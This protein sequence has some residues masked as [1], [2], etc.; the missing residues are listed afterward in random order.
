[1]N[2]I[3]SEK[4]ADTGKVFIYGERLNLS[5]MKN[6]YDNVA[7]CPQHNPLWEELTLFEHLELYATIKGISKSKVRD[8]CKEYVVAFSF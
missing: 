2:I 7:F 3:T 8:E 1:M 5:N 6:F 4:Q